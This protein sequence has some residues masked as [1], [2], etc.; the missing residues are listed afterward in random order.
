MLIAVSG[1]K[2][3]GALDIAQISNAELERWIQRVLG[4]FP[5]EY[6]R[7]GVK[8]TAWIASEHHQNTLAEAT[9]CGG[10]QDYAMKPILA[11]RHELNVVTI[12][13]PSCGHSSSLYVC[14]IA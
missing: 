2:N 7:C 12:K 9:W 10:R 13:P 3:C 5:R 1:F 11:C 14:I 4:R 8:L 6:A